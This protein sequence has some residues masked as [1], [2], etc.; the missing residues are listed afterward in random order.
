M[1]RAIGLPSPKGPDAM[2]PDHPH[3]IRMSGAVC[4]GKG[5]RSHR[6]GLT[7]AAATR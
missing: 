3:A 1:P 2:A 7:S 5:S 6:L 4:D